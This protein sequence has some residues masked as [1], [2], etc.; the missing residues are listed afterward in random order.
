LFSRNP[1]TEEQDTKCSG[2][3]LDRDADWTT[4]KQCLEHKSMVV[5]S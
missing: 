2:R 1:W 5:G 3:S 4:G